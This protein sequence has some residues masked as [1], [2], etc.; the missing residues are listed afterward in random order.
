[1][2]TQDTKTDTAHEKSTHYRIGT[3]S[4][5]SG[6]PV[7]TIRI[8]ERRYSVVNPMRSRGSDRLYSNTDIKRLALLK[9]LTE[10]GYSIGDIA[11]LDND[12]LEQQ[13]HEDQRAI[14][15][16]QKSRRHNG[17]IRV[18]VLGDVL[19][20]RIKAV[21]K[22]HEYHD[23]SY[24][25]LET[26]LGDFE[27]CLNRDEIDIMVLEYPAL[28]ADTSAEIKRLI[29]LAGTRHVFI[30]YGFG[31]KQQLEAFN[32]SSIT[33][34][35][36]PVALPALHQEIRKVFYAEPLSINNLYNMDSA[37]PAPE[38]IFTN[39][40]LVTAAGKSTSI[41]CECPQ[42]LSG[43]IQKLIQFEIYSSECENR[44]D[45]DRQLHQYLKN[46]TGHARALMEN[47]LKQTLEAEGYNF[48]SLLA[49]SGKYHV[50][51]D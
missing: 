34:L 46:V 32:D 50:G 12:K 9:K 16:L 40:G 22:E 51:Q 18:A 48:E 1:M 19:P 2:N 23:F 24:V 42:H 27:S 36:A 26:H 30:V 10:R 15:D 31:A 4:R 44:D 28:Q 35:Q 29:K 38:R 49:E 41:K 7:D 25:S 45:K 6:I 37:G 17:L 20:L 33:L 43:I 21:K 39:Q 14:I 3:A 13:L 11:R 8:W 5:L 47:A